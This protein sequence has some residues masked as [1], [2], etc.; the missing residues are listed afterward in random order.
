MK[1]TC[2]ACAA[3]LITGHEVIVALDIEELAE[4]IAHLEERHGESDY[5]SECPACT[6]LQK[7][8][9]AKLTHFTGEGADG[10]REDG[11]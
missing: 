3:P 7:L 8:I 10:V 4:I 1:P 11:K 5:E 6:G 2:G 9:A